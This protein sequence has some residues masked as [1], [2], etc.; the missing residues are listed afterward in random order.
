MND[1]NLLSNALIEHQKQLSMKS[2]M[3]LVESPLLYYLK[4]CLDIFEYS[5]YCTLL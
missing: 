1:A 4:F 5:I 2:C 3:F